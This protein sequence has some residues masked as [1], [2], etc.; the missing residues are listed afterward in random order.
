MVLG[1]IVV[2]ANPT[3]GST[4]QLAGQSTQHNSVSVNINVDTN[5]HRSQ[6]EIKL[7]FSSTVNSSRV[8]GVGGGGGGAES[9]NNENTTR[10][11]SGPSSNGM[12]FK[13]EQQTS[14]GGGGGMFGG[15]RLPGDENPNLST[16][17]FDYDEFRNIFDNNFDDLFLDDFEAGGGGGGVTVD[18][19]KDLKSPTM[20]AAALAGPTQSSATAYVN[21]RQSQATYTD[22]TSN[23]PT[24]PD[25]FGAP[26]TQMTLGGAMDS[27]SGST[28]HTTPLLS[29]SAGPAAETLKLMAAQHQNQELYGKA[30]GGQFGSGDAYQNGYISLYSRTPMYTSMQQGMYASTGAY[31]SSPGTGGLGVGELGANCTVGPQPQRRP[32]SDGMVHAG[33]AVP[34]GCTMIPG[35]TNMPPDSAAYRAAKMSSMYPADVPASSSSIRQLENQVQSHFGSTSL[36]SSN[37]TDERIRFQREAEH[38]MLQ[39]RR[40]QMGGQQQ[41]SMQQQQSMQLQG[42]QGMMQQQQGMMIQQN[43]GMQF[44]MSQQMNIQAGGGVGNGGLQN[45]RHVPSSCQ[46]TNCPTMMGPLTTR[47]APAGTMRERMLAQEQRVGYHQAQQQQQQLLDE[48]QMQQHIMQQRQQYAAAAYAASHRSHPY[49][50]PS[51]MMSSAYQTN[52]SSS[53]GLHGMQPQHVNPSSGVGGAIHGMQANLPSGLVGGMGH[54]LQ[55][56]VGMPLQRS[57]PS[58]HV[59]MQSQQGG[60]LHRVA[61]APAGVGRQ[62]QQDLCDVQPQM[63]GGGRASSH[64]MMGVPGDGGVGTIG[65]CVYPP[66]QGGMAVSMHQQQ[67]FVSNV[68]HHGTQQPQQHPGFHDQVTTPANTQKLPSG[69]T[70]SMPRHEH[71]R[72]AEQIAYGGRL[73]A[74]NEAYNNFALQRGSAARPSPN[75]MVGPSGVVGNLVSNK[76]VDWSTTQQQINN[77]TVENPQLREMVCEN[78]EDSMLENS[79]TTDL[80][81][82]NSHRGVGVGGGEWSDS[83]GYPHGGVNP[84]NVVFRPGCDSSLLMSQSQAMQL[85]NYSINGGAPTSSGGRGGLEYMQGGGGGGGAGSQHALVSAEQSQH[86]AYFNEML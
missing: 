81:L 57:M 60:H 78:Y 65:E 71:P 43:G 73:A 1:G 63:F 5:L 35:S 37:G 23:T 54:G 42:M 34:P 14:M 4:G 40:Q 86:A 25:A 11:D 21:G 38:Q 69:F 28:P 19:N 66:Q 49:R 12:Q 36:P 29:D 77:G 68:P 50:M 83:P 22:Y 7:T 20:T 6:S 72:T 51:S 18:C 3:N 32:E 17:D 67:S 59:G 75:I 80:L 39:Q 46:Q 61:G 76:R 31:C 16:D 82:A 64:S 52:P 70:S 24:Y 85:R 27:Q 15:D 13:M 41:I 79:M 47:S 2:G 30:S 45:G 74:Q 62:Q 8:D 9:V 84:R 10:Q 53:S 58:Q 48:R 26:P 55:P 56:H 44:H 33:S